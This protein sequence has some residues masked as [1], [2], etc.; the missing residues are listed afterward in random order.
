MLA[1]ARTFI[2]IISDQDVSWRIPSSGM[3][4]RV[5]L[6]LADVSY[7]IYTASHPMRGIR[8]SH[9]RENLQS[10]KMFLIHD[11][12]CSEASGVTS[13]ASPRPCKGDRPAALFC[14]SHDQCMTVLW[15]E[16]N[17]R[18]WF[19]GA[20]CKFMSSRN[21]RGMFSPSLLIYSVFS[22]PSKCRPFY[23]QS[24]KLGAQWD[25]FLNSPVKNVTEQTLPSFTGKCSRAGSRV[26]MY[27]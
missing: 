21:S 5:D 15:N 23:W 19:L 10:Y 17:E 8:H 11:L 16:E 2:F 18:T 24:Q 27:V 13:F 26:N 6:M 3:W 14:F 4:P 22:L 1:L 20:S 12:R 25:S 7:K 9:R